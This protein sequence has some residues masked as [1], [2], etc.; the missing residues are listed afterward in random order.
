MSRLKINSREKKFLVKQQ[1]LYDKVHDTNQRLLGLLQVITPVPKFVNLVRRTV[2][3]CETIV[4][5]PKYKKQERAKAQEFLDFY[6]M[7]TEGKED[8]EIMGKLGLTDPTKS[9]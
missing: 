7:T 4:G 3:V 1:E 6:D 9:N 5:D 8:E 2:L